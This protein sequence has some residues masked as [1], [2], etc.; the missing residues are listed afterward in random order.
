MSQ[1]LCEWLLR[2]NGDSHSTSVK[3]EAPIETFID[4]APSNENIAR[5]TAQSFWQI[6]DAEE[7]AE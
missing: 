2:D 1:P 5:Q 3:V 4:P 6:L 7:T